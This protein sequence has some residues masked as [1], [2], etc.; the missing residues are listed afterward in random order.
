MRRL[1]D[2]KD[3]P[4][5]KFYNGKVQN[6]AVQLTLLGIIALQP[7][8]CQAG[9]VLALTTPLGLSHIVNLRRIAEELAQQRGHHI[10]VS[11]LPYDGPLTDL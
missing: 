1:L 2:R 11:L 10:T 3:H 6:V 8:M 5:L 9:K 4:Y 7:R